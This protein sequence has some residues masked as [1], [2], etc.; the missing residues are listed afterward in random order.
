MVI[1][2]ATGKSLKVIGTVTSRQPP[3][4]NVHVPLLGPVMIRPG[5]IIVPEY[6]YG[7]RDRN[8]CP[9]G[10]ATTV[11]RYA[12]GVLRPE[13]TI[14]KRRPS[15]RARRLDLHGVN[16]ANV[17]LPGRVCGASHAIHLR[18]GTAFVAQ[19]R[20]G[21][22]WRRKVHWPAWPRITVYAGWNAVVYGDLD[23]DGEDETALGVDC[24]IPRGTAG[25]VLANAQVIFTAAVAS[26]RAIGLVTPRS[27]DTY[28]TPRAQVEIRRGKIVA[29]EF[30]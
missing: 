25:S 22:R 16:W 29:H 1:F 21:R 23:G 30:W 13:T 19:T 11:W 15:Q 6:W 2:T 8:C 18:G 28:G 27:P 7:T 26:P 17:A 9:S 3:T 14:I 20:W 12:N 5:R 10:R 4:P 24:S